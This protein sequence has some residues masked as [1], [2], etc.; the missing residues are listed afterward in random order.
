MK[1][2]SKPVQR[3]I[4]VWI[5]GNGDVPQALFLLAD[6]MSTLHS[7]F[8]AFAEEPVGLQDATMAEDFEFVRQKR[9]SAQSTKALVERLE[10][11]KTLRVYDLHKAT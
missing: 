10:V 3:S 5:F 11:L 7:G 8:A 6:N 2:L 4:K 9:R 1:F